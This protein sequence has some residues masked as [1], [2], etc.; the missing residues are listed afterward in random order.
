MGAGLAR[1]SER[2]EATR[3]TLIEAARACF[4][5]L[6]FEATST[7]AVLARAGV[8]KGALYHHFDSKVDLLAAVFDAVSREVV[9]RAQVAARQ[10]ASPRDALALTLKA[11]LRVV[12]AP[13]PRRIILETG[14]AVLGFARA[15]EIEDRITQEPMRRNLSRVA[16]GG[17]GT[18]ADVDLA[19]RLLNA[20]VYELAL[21]ALTRNL[22]EAGMAR[23]DPYIDAVMDML[24]PL[25]P[26]GG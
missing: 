10:T 17:E 4:A 22:D 13:E 3:A 18:C 14:P 16:E 25:P 23:L 19:A 11:W 8:S 9:A 7:D 21:T 6:G 20:T 5:E 15:R 26:H 2:R 12:L 24:L 1:Q